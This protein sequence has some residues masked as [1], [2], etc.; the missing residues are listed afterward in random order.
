MM[1]SLPR[2]NRQTSVAGQQDHGHER[3]IAQA[4]TRSLPPTGPQLNR[5]LLPIAL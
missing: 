2:C 3:I 4:P 5:V 1:D